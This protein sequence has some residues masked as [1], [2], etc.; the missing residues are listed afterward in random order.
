MQQIDHNSEPQG[1]SAYTPMVA[2]YTPYPTQPSTPPPPP[3]TRQKKQSMPPVAPVVVA[4]IATDTKPNGLTQVLTTI[5]ARVP[6]K[7]KKRRNLQHLIEHRLE[8]PVFFLVTLVMVSRTAQMFSGGV[9]IM[10]RLLGDK[11]PI[12]E[13]VTGV[14]L[15]IG[16]EMLMTIS[17][18]SW[19]NW[20]SEATDTQSRAGMSKIA[21]DA[22][23]RR[24]RDNAKYSRIVMFVGMGASVFAG[25]SY[26]FTNSG[27]PLDQTTFSNPN[28]WVQV[29][30][31][32]VAVCV[33]TT[34]VFYLGVLKETRG[35]SEAE[36]AL[37]ELDEGLNDAVK[38][39]I[40]RF[41]DGKQTPVDEKLIAEH[42]SPGRKAKF[43]RSVAKVNK[44]KVW[45]AGELRKRLGYGNDATKIRRLNLAINQL[46]KDPD[47]ALEKAEDGRTW[48]I[49]VRVV[50]EHWGDAIAAHDAQMLVQASIPNNIQTA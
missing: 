26:L 38:A 8:T 50:W 13:I 14:G 28:F 33:V 17:G 3:P 1:A 45:T 6:R 5:F 29:F 39:A 7:H 31:D 19:R 10:S 41:R 49:P 46:A 21:R 40:T 36:E 2:Q 35:A 34:C 44:G 22:Y 12:F 25:L 16:S 27:K 20:E 32:F 11:Y 30:V 42:L 48:L 47:N 9:L 4:P 15:G 24:A 43:L 23:V 18:R 37:A